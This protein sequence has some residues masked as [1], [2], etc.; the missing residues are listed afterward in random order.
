MSLT[1]MISTC[2]LLG[3]DKTPR[4]YNFLRALKTQKRHSGRGKKRVKESP[5]MTRGQSKN[6][7]KSINSFQEAIHGSLLAILA[8]RRMFVLKTIPDLPA[9]VD[10]PK[11]Y[12]FSLEKEN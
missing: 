11:S 7:L 12:N 6:R 4:E 9:N 10:R 2:L 1:T 8:K 3:K 5:Q